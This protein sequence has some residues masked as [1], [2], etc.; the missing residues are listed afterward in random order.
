M[1]DNEFVWAEPEEDVEMLIPAVPLFWAALGLPRDPPI[2]TDIYGIETAEGRSW[3]YGVGGDT[4]EYHVARVPQLRFLAEM[5]Q[6]DNVLG[7]V[8]VNYDD[9][10]RLPT[11]AT[12]TF[13][14]TA[15][16]FVLDVTDIDT[17]ITLTA[18]VWKRP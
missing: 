3:R 17:T 6:F 11:R 15:S 14:E 2:G 18:D 13:P 8:E 10:T 7:R 12:L 16:L 5:R 1:D 9:Q 4:L